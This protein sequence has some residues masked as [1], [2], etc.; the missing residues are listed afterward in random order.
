MK[1]RQANDL[2]Y[3]SSANNKYE[4]LI[5]NSIKLSWNVEG[6]TKK[7]SNTFFIRTDSNPWELSDFKGD[8]EISTTYKSI[9]LTNV[10]GPVIANTIGGNIKVVFDAISPSK[11][12]SLVSNDGYIDI[13]L[14]DD[15]DIKVDARGDRILSNIDFKILNE[16]IE[17][18]TKGMELQL[19]SGKTKLKL[20][21]GSGNVYLRKQE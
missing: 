9:E 14:P 5:P 6:C 7:N 19:N 8:V 18:G 11:L 4:I 20:D 10:S 15:A 3:F 13:T 21:A 1:L 17:E 2:V 16:T 12:Y